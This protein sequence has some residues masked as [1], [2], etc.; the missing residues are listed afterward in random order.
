MRLLTKW[1][2][3][4]VPVRVRSRVVAVPVER[5]RVRPVVHVSTR[6]DHRSRVPLSPYIYELLIFLF[7]PP[8]LLSVSEFCRGESSRH[9][10]VSVPLP[11]APGD[12]SPPVPLEMVTF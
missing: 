3:A 6:D 2:T 7:L 4:D 8:T 5:T 11:E 12:I 9:V 1:A 10:C